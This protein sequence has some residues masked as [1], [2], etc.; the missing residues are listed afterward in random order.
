MCLFVD[1]T[2]LSNA[3]LKVALQAAFELSSYCHTC[4][5]VFWQPLQESAPAVQVHCLPFAHLAPNHHAM[6]LLCC[7][8]LPL[9][10]MSAH[11]TAAP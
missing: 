5:Q 9:D 10:V 11:S 7:S 4:W 3:V 1:E 6:S 8:C 2:S